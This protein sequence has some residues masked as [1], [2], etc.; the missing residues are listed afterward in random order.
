MES[1][2]SPTFEAIDNSPRGAYLEAHLNNLHRDSDFSVASI[3]TE[4]PSP[5]WSNATPFAIKPFGIDV[6]QSDGQIS[7]SDP[8]W[9][10][11]DKNIGPRSEESNAVDLIKMESVKEELYEQAFERIKE[12]EPE[13]AQPDLISHFATGPVSLMDAVAVLNGDLVD[14]HNRHAIVIRENQEMSSMIDYLQDINHKLMLPGGAAQYLSEK[15]QQITNQIEL[16]QYLRQCRDSTMTQLQI[17]DQEGSARNR[18]VYQQD[19]EIIALH[20]RNEELE[21]WAGLRI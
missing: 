20:R 9:N 3:K 12:E 7:L 19:A 13:E 16:I 11:A 8:F 1:F 2:R 17:K 10:T 6:G 4:S 14:L 15:N 21:R 18:V 5:S